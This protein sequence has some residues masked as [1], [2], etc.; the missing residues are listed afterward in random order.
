MDGQ[1]NGRRNGHGS[2]VMEQTREEATFFWN[3]VVSIRSDLQQLAA[4]EVRLLQAEVAEQ[5]GIV[6]QVAMWG[7]VAAILALLLLS[8]SFVTVMFALDTAMDTWL[9]ALITTLLIATLAGAC[10]LVA[11]S[12]LKAF[13]LTPKRTINSLKEDV[14]WAKD[15][16]KSNKT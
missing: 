9:A 2:G 8:F 5:T 6:R 1:H 7:G 4:A 11:R 16:V 13:S 12:R 14:E 10:A 15:L 3:E